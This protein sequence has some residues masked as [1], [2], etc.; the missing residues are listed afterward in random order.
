M[1]FFWESVIIGMKTHVK[2]AKA[3]Y[4]LT[5]TGGKYRELFQSYQNISIDESMV[6][7]K[8]R[9]AFINWQNV[10]WNYGC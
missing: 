10:G 2:L 6:E 8:G 9:H 3:R 7:N 4:F 1:I 5:Y